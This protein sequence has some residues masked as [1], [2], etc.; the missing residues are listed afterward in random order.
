[1]KCQPYWWDDAPRPEIPNSPLPETADVAIVG[2]GY[3]GLHAAI[4]L[5]RAGRSVIVFDA[6][7]AAWGCSAR[8]GGQMSTGVK[9]SINELCTRY[10]K[11][12]GHAIIREG[13]NSLNYVKEFITSENLDCDL[14][15][16]GRFIGAHR[17]NRYEGLAT[18][19]EGMSKIVPFE[20]AMVPKKEMASELGTDLYHGGAVIG[21][22][23]SIQPAKYANE[24][25]RLALEAGCAIETRTPA[26]AISCNGSRSTV[27]TTR[28]TV[29]ARDVVVATNGYT[30]KV[31]LNLRRRIIPIGSYM[32]ATE[33]IEPQ[34]MQRIMPR[35]RVV[36]DTR[37]VIYYYR[38]S[39]DHKRLVFG[40]RVALTETDPRV[41]A[42]RL[43]QVVSELFPE[44]SGTGISHS[45]M[46]FVAY[47]FDHLPHIGKRDGVWFA[48][49]YC[50]SG[51]DWASYFGHKL[52]H[53]ILGNREGSTAFDDL[54]WPTRPLYNG[55]PWFL[56]PTL[57]WYKTMDRWGP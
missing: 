15:R 27:T 43:H 48:A 39:P 51:I 9:P 13:F 57:A 37:K 17:P 3:T 29:E 35:Q 23:A 26:T 38:P 31:S 4:V 21:H 34:I 46:G 12:G 44:L 2:S 40:G 47:T 19:L 5:A 10:G 1:M 24:L 30:G 16:D 8:N 50:G 56:G 52:G 41:S 7:D 25:I 54:P 36:N 14:I 28:G 53:K 11:E 49:G 20:W 33:P 42:P 55:I 45:W 32:I 18:Y 22:H 6:E